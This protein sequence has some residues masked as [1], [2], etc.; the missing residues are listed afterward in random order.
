M[1]TTVNLDALADLAGAVVRA[2]ADLRA[3]AEKRDA[4]I[5]EALTAGARPVDV[6]RATGL[7]RER[8]Y[9]IKG[10]RR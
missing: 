8:I 10:G 9:Q 7:S 6:V 5:R 1:T 4:A 3:L 2:E